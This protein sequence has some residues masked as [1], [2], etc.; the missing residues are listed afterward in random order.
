MSD[1]LWPHGLQHARL[2]CPSPAN[3]IV[4][5]KRLKRFSSK[6]RGNTRLMKPVNLKGN[7]PWIF[8]RRTDAEVETPIFWSSKVNSW[9]IGKVHEAGKDR[10]HKEKR[11][12]EDEM[13]EWY[14][15]H[16][17]HE[18]GQI[19]GT[20]EGQRGLACDSPWGCTESDM[21]GW[22]NNSNKGVYSHHSYSTSY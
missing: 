1:S 3:I 15:Q 4:N 22:L 2:P 17:G 19:W 12:S 11:A 7:Q 13:A 8:I 9:F 21:P 14:H 10:G 5:E 20:D 6:I 18:L 16:N